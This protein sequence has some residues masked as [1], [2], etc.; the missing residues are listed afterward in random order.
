MGALWAWTRQEM[1]RRIE[2]TT[3]LRL[4]VLDRTVKAV[5]LTVGGIALLIAERTGALTNLTSE[6]Q[7]QLN[8]NSGS[9]LW[10]RLINALLQRFGS[11]SSTARTAL[12]IAILL[13]ALLEAVEA[14]GV[15]ARRRW[16]EYLVLL[17]TVAFI[18]VEVDELVRR[19]SIWKALTLLI[20]IAIA[21]YLVWRK[22]LFMPA[23]SA[24]TTIAGD[25]VAAGL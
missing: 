1:S 4:I 20:N 17:A 6:V 24:A 14:I 13:Y 7:E 12:A 9:H 22:R 2:L 25:A 19:P 5:V 15:L 8:L 21:V 18:P 10:L 23:R 16:A 3:G 11:L